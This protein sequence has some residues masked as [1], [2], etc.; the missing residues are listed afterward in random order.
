MKAA[1]R[2]RAPSIAHAAARPASSGECADKNADVASLSCLASHF[3]ASLDG[4]VESHLRKH[5]NLS[6]IGRIKPVLR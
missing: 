1:S 4:P 5:Q 6:D 3:S 2:W